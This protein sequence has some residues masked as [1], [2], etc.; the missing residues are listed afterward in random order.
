MSE[1]LTE[2]ALERARPMPEGL[3]AAEF[4]RLYEEHA[5]YVRGLLARLLGPGADV[6]DLAQETFLAATR[7]ANWHRA[8]IP[9]RAWLCGIA[10]QLARAARRRQRLRRFLGLVPALGMPADSTPESL[11][12]S[13]EASRIVYSILDRLS[14]KRRTVFILFE[15]QELSGQEIAAALGCPLA[16]VKTRLFHA[17]RDFEQELGRW[18]ADEQRRAAQ[19]R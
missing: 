16:T 11:F 13:K 15:L 7:R 19:K 12:E 5:D 1:S 6:D 8:G 3:S 18:S 10:V 4:Q 2:P 9:E 17:R 14:E